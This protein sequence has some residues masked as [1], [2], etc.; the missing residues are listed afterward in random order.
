MFAGPTMPSVSATWH[1]CSISSQS[2]IVSPRIDS[3]PFDSIIVRG[4]APRQRASRSQK[5]STE[6]SVPP[7]TCCTI[8]GT[9]RVA[10]EELELR[11]VGGAPDVP[12]AEAAARLDEH[13]ERARRPAPRRRPTSAATRCPARSKKRC[14]TYLSSQ[15]RIAP[16]RRSSTSAPS[17]SR[18]SASSMWSRSASGTTSRDVVQLDQRRAARRCSPGRRRAARSRAGR[19]R[20]APARARSRRP[21]AWS[22]RPARTR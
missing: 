16:A 11:T 14:A 13:R 17:A 20:T 15:S 2:L 1:A 7:H 8:D 10:E 12:R 18:C 21:R 3:P 9:R 4:T 19:R 5:T 22:R 6:N